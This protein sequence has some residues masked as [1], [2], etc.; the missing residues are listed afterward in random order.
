[1]PIQ[2]RLHLPPALRAA[3]QAHIETSPT[4]EVC[5]LVYGRWHPFP[6]WGQAQGLVRMTNCAPTP[7]TRYMMAADELLKA[8]LDFEKN[9]HDLL[10]I[11]HSHPNG[12]IR[13]SASDLAEATYPEA[14]YL[15]GTP[16]GALNGWRLVR[17]Q[18]FPV[19]LTV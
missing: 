10:A 12:D 15:I 7:T 4:L 6:R 1:M 18:A 13:P 3:L 8:L 16:Q 9:G 2:T 19:M 11:Y 14:V 17:G 5:G